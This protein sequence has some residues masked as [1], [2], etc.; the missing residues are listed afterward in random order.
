VHAGVGS[1]RL[2]AVTAVHRYKF[3]T[4]CTD[5]DRDARVDSTSE[6]ALMLSVSGSLCRLHYTT[7]GSGADVA[8]AHV[9]A[10]AR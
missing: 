1:T 2:T 8:Q 9:H 7:A 4:L 5:A 3:E 10:A 6:F